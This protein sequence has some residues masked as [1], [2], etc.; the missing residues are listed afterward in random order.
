MTDKA[1]RRKFLKTALAA[2]AGIAGVGSTSCISAACYTS[3]FS[4]YKEIPCPECQR[5]MKVGEKD[6]LLREYNVPLKRI[7]DSGIDAT[8]T[9]P[10]HC[11][12]CGFGLRKGKFYVEFKYP[13]RPTPVR[14]ELESATA[15]EKLALH[16]VKKKQEEHG[17]TL[18]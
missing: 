10:E 7:Q 17:A 18:E 3:V 14:I 11:S 6:D 4:S 9:V 13:D 16:E 2:L 5:T 12:E 15:L 8:L 1:E